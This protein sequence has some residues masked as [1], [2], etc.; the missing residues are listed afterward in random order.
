MT[1][2]SATDTTSTD[3][4]PTEP[5][6]PGRR[7]SPYLIVAVIASAAFVIAFL[8]FRGGSGSDDAA[9][10]A[11]CGD[12]KAGTGYAVSVGSDPDPPKA[13]GTT[14]HLTVRHDG[15]AVTGAKV[16]INADMA[17]MHH[18]GIGGPAKEAGGGTYDA[19]LK[20]GMRG[21]YAAS[22]V[23]REKGKPAVAV[24]LSF[25]VG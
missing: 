5:A 11:S 22:V 14:F 7:L 9:A 13:E 19:T 1:D 18:E 4:N 20:F 3:P 6:A 8:A 2:P 21:P 17:E 25:Q 10:G 12:A 23:I 15:Q 24:P 16:C